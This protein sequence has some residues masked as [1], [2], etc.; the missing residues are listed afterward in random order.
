[1]T[2]PSG[3]P[4]SGPAPIPPGPVD[5]TTLDQIQQYLWTRYVDH[6]RPALELDESWALD[7]LETHYGSSPMTADPNCFY[8]GILAYER[9]FSASQRGRNR[10]L[11]RALEAFTS[12]IGQVPTGSSWEPVDDRLQEVRELLGLGNEAEL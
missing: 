4:V 2:P 10:L 11:N 5:E 8:Y 12:Y 6:E 9:S 7:M 3:P 1:M